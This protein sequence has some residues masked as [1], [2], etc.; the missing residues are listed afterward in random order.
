[1]NDTLDRL[2]RA[3]IRFDAGDPCRIQHLTKVW[4]Y[5]ALIGREERLSDE[6][7]FILESAALLHD[8]GIHIAEQKYGHQNGKLQEQEGPEGV[9]SVLGEIG[10]YTQEQTERI[11]WLVA[12]HHTYHASE[13]ID[14][15][16]LI[17]ADFL[18]NLY[19]DQEPKEVAE[20]VC[21]NIFRTKSGKSLLKDMFLTEYTF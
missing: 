3:M 21:S 1:M 8:I 11:C 17:E 19:E 16:I 15:Q 18:V 10:G 14:Y 5:A 4:S 6:Q 13:D 2:H 9:R 12:H 20:K 7:Q